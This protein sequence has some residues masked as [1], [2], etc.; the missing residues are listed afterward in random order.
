MPRPSP[1]L[2]PARPARLAPLALFALAYLAVLAVLFAPDGFFLIPDPAPD[3][4]PDMPL[5]AAGSP[6]DPPP[7]P[8]AD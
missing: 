1:I 5:A 8:G 3:A 6:T 7:A 4:V 2:R